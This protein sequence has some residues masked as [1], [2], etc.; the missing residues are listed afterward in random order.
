MKGELDQAKERARVAELRLENAQAVAARS[1][2]AYRARI[3]EL[4]A[5]LSAAE[6]LTH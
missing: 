3:A 4:E 5:K 2:A 6:S 1:D